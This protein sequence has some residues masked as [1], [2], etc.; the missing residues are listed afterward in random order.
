MKLTYIFKKGFIKEAVNQETSYIAERQPSMEVP[1]FKDGTIN[2][3]EQLFVFDEHQQTLFDRYFVEA[4]AQLMLVIP[5]GYM[6]SDLVEPE[7]PGDDLISELEINDFP[8]QF[9][10]P[11]YVKMR[12]Y[13]I[14]H[15]IW[16][17]LDGKLPAIAKTFFDRLEVT[18][19]DIS[20]LLSKRTRSMRRYPSFP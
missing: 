5:A 1:Q 10:S 13:I 9:V 14:E 15:I 16:R 17:W 12:Q 4:Y 20:D 8:K 2:L 19:K 7:P 3:F 18:R 11:L 6:Y